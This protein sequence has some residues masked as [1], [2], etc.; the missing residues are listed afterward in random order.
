MSCL[1]ILTEDQNEL[2]QKTL[3][4][5][6]E[7]EG[8]HC[9]AIPLQKKAV[10]DQLVKRLPDLVLVD[11]IQPPTGEVWSVQQLLQTERDFRT[12]PLLFQLPKGQEGALDVSQGLVD[13][14]L[15][16]YSFSEL[17]SRIR[18]ILW[19][20]R[21]ISGKE[22]VQHDNL[23]IDLERYEVTLNGQRI[24]LTFKEYELLK[25]LATNPGKVFTRDSL[26]NKVWGYEYYGGTRTVDV[27]VR[28]LRSKI[29]DSTHQFIETVRGVGYKFLS[30]N[31]LT[32]TPSLIPT[33]KKKQSQ[34]KIRPKSLQRKK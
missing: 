15:K 21:R 29:E 32:P 6:L 28:R 20:H 1:L 5:G 11:L 19:R 14:I 10:F 9:E 3:H 31:G 18:L 12:I 23:L 2:E 27:H 33:R 34:K 8:F 26:L 24:D 16:P 22:T 13:F 30:E 25:F 17:L 4:R 7:R